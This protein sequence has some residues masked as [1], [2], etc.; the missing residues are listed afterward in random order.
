MQT[1]ALGYFLFDKITFTIT[2]KYPYFGIL[3]GSIQS[4]FGA[5]NICVTVTNKALGC[6]AGL[7]PLSVSQ[8]A[9]EQ[10]ERKGDRAH[11]WWLNLEVWRDHALRQAEWHPYP[12][13][14][15]TSLVYALLTSLR[16]IQAAGL[17]AHYERHARA[18]QMVRAGLR[19]MGSA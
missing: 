7:A 19:R 13:T 17:D 16:R 3:I 10:I 2:E 1:I 9:W 4:H 14:M 6:P 8:R 15:P 12:T 18:A 11:G 5:E